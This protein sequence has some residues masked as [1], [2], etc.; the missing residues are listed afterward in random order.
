MIS[1]APARRLA[2][3]TTIAQGPCQAV[4]L[5]LNGTL[6][7][8]VLADSPREYQLI[9]ESAEAVALLCRAGFVCP[10]VTVQSRIEK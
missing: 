2:D 10:V 4:F 1:L 8:P 3:D 7:L 6:V 5:D 9:A